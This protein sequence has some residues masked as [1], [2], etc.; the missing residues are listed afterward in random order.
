VVQFHHQITFEVLNSLVSVTYYSKREHFFFK[1]TTGK[2]QPVLAGNISE[3][4]VLCDYIL[5]F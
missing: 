2:E 1:D 3:R 5:L 4:L